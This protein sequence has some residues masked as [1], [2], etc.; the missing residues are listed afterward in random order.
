MKLIQEAC[1]SFFTKLGE[2]KEK[3]KKKKGHLVILGR[4]K[5]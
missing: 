4:V 3:R 5:Q 1:Y 2:R